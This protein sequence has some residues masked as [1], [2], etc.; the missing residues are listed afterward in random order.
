M[1]SWIMPLV[2]GLC[3]GIGGA[4]P[5]GVTYAQTKNPPPKLCVPISDTNLETVKQ[6]A[7]AYNA[8]SGQQLTVGEYALQALKVIAVSEVTKADQ[9]RM[10]ALSQGWGEK[11]ARPA[12]QQ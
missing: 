6:A 10:N 1:G 11:A 12:G 7:E 2:I 9:Q 4:F 3:L 5:M 8:R